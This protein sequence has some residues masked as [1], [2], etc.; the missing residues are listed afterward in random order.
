MY[1]GG[2]RHRLIKDNVKRQVTEGLDSLGW[3]NTARRHKPVEVL[4]TQLDPS[5]EITPNKVCVFIEDF[6][7]AEM[8]MGQDWNLTET[9]INCFLE[10]FA[11]NGSIGQE[12]TGD[13]YDIL[14]G[15]FNAINDDTSVAVY[16][17]T[18]D[19]ELLFH[20]D[21]EDIE[22][23]RSRNWDLPFNKY[24]WTIAVDIIDTYRDDRDD[25]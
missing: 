13:I 1:V 20:C 6:N 15:K 12:L 9:R 17:L 2:K 21:Y 18:G 14:R 3:F 7:D 23:M 4:G 25:D 24:W 5:E 22:V 16:D 10:V 8:G 11:E 19:N